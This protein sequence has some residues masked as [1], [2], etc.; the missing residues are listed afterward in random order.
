MLNST[1]RPKYWSRSF[2]NKADYDA[3]KI[4]WKYKKETSKVDINTYDTTI[5]GYGNTGH[6]Y[7]DKF[8]ADERK[9]VI[10]YLKTL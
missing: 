3:A 5:Y 6:I 1:K 7:G 8:T 2:D 9:A 4:G 10:E